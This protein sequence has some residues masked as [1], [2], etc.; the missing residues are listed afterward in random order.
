MESG[1][2]LVC[3][4][5]YKVLQNKAVEDFRNTFANLAVPLF[6]MS[7]PLPPKTFKFEDMSWTLW[8]RWILEGD[9]TVQDVLEWFRVSLVLS[10]LHCAAAWSLTSMSAC[11]HGPTPALL[12]L[13]GHGQS[14]DTW[15]SRANP[16]LLCVHGCAVVRCLIDVCL[17]RIRT[18]RPTACPPGRRCCT[19]TSSPSTG[20]VL[21]ASCLTWSRYVA[22]VLVP[23]TPARASC[24]RQ[25]A[26]CPLTSSNDSIACHTLNYVV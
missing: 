15:S 26:V 4:E 5:L 6:A 9:L 12:A 10:S 8:D 1:A 19:T 18:W 21:A 23:G 3:L 11:W 24:S 22:A 13:I 14:A 2:G 20:S 7:E 25:G 17:C 16:S